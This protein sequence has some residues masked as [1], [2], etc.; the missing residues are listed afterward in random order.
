M[1]PIPEA[2]YEE[3]LHARRAK[4]SVDRYIQMME[5]GILTEEDR[6]ELINGEIIRMDPKEGRHAATVDKI[7]AFFRG[8]LLI[9]EGA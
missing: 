3:I 7:M 6:V 4:I 9:P 8:P 5:L 1:S 2:K